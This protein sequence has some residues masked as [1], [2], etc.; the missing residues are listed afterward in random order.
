MASLPA[1]KKRVFSIVV[2]PNTAEQRIKQSQ[3][4]VQD[5]TLGCAIGLAHLCSLV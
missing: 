2:F 5:P 3:L 1:P 4:G